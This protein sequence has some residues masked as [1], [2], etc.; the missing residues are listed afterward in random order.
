[1]KRTRAERRAEKRRKFQRVLKMVVGWSM[2]NRPIEDIV[3]DAKKST[4]NPQRCNGYCCQNARRSNRHRKM[5]QLTPQ[6]LRSMLGMQQDLNDLG[7]D[8]KIDIKETL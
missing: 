8:D 3:M 1:M 6:E 2:R 7:S 5:S 4:D